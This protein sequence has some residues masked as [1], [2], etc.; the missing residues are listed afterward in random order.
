MQ[1]ARTK[2]QKTVT[3]REDDQWR[4]L[5]SAGWRPFRPTADEVWRAIFRLHRAATAFGGSSTIGDRRGC[6]GNVDRQGSSNDSGGGGV[7][8]TTSVDAGVSAAGG[9]EGSGV[10]NDKPRFSENVDPD[11]SGGGGGGGSRKRTGSNGWKKAPR[12]VDI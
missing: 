11:A 6:S 12:G 9:A 5:R 10:M 1:A 3:E 4:M 2:S 7:S 8:K